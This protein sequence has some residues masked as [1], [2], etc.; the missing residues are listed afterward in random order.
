MKFFAAALA[1]TSAI[2]IRT[3]HRQ[4]ASGTDASGDTKEEGHT[5]RGELDN[6]WGEI[7]SIWQFIVDDHQEKTK[8]V[9]HDDDEGRE[10]DE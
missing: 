6:L 8:A 2:T 4:D 5:L 3:H 10:H 9:H 1:L 7:D